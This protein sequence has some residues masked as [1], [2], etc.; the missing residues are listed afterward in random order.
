M[1]DQ[2]WNSALT[3]KRLRLE[4][5][6]EA[7]ANA[8]IQALKDPRTFEFVRD[9]P[10]V[11]PQAFADRLRQLESRVSKDGSTHWLNWTVFSGLN[12]IGTVQ[13][14]ATASSASA[15][16]AYMFHPDSWGQ[17]FAHESCVILIEH[18]HSCGI[19]SFAAY[20]DTRNKASHKLL[21]RLGFIQKQEIKNADEFKGSVSHDFVY[22]LEF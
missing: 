12:V 15:N 14:D 10:P 4:P 5:Q 13:A 22:A 18:L 6:I 7:H 17:G 11:D 2:A 21:K 16:I 20:T 9:D 1:T 19:K 3:T 8:L